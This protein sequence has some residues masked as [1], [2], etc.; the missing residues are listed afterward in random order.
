MEFE[1]GKKLSEKISI[2]L[3]RMDEMNPSYSK[4]EEVIEAEYQRIQKK[5]NPEQEI[6]IQKELNHHFRDFL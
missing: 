2:A 3:E 5:L 4:I 1:T 6:D